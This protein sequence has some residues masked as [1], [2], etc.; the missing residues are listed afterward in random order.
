MRSL[1]WL[2]LSDTCPRVTV[3]LAQASANA[4][5][6]LSLIRGEVLLPEPGPA[7]VTEQ[8]GCRTPGDEIAVQDG[9]DLVLQPGPLAHD[10][11]P[12]GHLAPE[13]VRVLIRQPH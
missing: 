8:V 2:S 13:S 9:L 10:V 6:P 11:G 7:L 5:V 12:A 4:T 3:H 1:N